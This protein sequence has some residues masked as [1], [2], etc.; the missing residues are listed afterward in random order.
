M[1]AT[2]AKV[3]PNIGQSKEATKT[4]GRPFKVE[5]SD[6]DLVD[7]IQ[8]LARE[9]ESMDDVSSVAS[10][11][12]RL[13]PSSKLTVLWAKKRF[14]RQGIRS[15]RKVGQQRKLS[16]G[17]TTRVEVGHLPLRQVQSNGQYPD[18]W[19]WTQKDH[20]ESHP[21]E[22]SLNNSQPISQ[23][24]WPSSAASLS[25]ESEYS[26]GTIAAPLDQES[27]S[28]AE[29]KQP[30]AIKLVVPQ[31]ITSVD[32]HLGCTPTTALDV[33]LLIRKDIPYRL[34]EN[35]ET[36]MNE[37]D[38]PVEQ[39]IDAIQQRSEEGRQVY[40]TSRSRGEPNVKHPK[41][42]SPEVSTVLTNNKY[43]DHQ[44]YT[45]KVV[46]TGPRSQLTADSR[47]K[48]AT[49]RKIMSKRSGLS[50]KNSATLVPYKS[51]NSKHKDSEHPATTSRS[52][53]RTEGNSRKRRRNVDG[54]CQKC[55][56]PLEKKLAVKW[57]EKEWD[58]FWT[59]VSCAA[60]DIRTLREHGLDDNEACVGL[61]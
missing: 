58:H 44:A 24:R 18:S 40:M 22:G 52:R 5:M 13:S 29:E 15:T 28:D 30:E 3:G 35:G 6:Q 4:D 42:V 47:N 20:D 39:A 37:L 55:R 10:E 2:T 11:S 27:I 41:F 54:L 23:T 32:E 60:S 7:Q 48:L 14:P 50:T 51:R 36:I 57:S 33:Q 61:L 34:K 17:A 12:Q 25:E 46:P 8:E 21:L 19:E 31:S 1:A 9:I 53:N 26:I 16:F 56:K 43:W 49:A 38:I 45:R 59:K